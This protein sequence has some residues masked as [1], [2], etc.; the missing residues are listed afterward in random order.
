MTIN[1]TTI[2][3]AT[4]AVRIGVPTRVVAACPS[5]AVITEPAARERALAP[6]QAMSTGHVR[7][8]AD[9]TGFAETPAWSPPT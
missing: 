4:D 7:L 1:L 5:S 9:A 3:A 6:N 8:G 2:T